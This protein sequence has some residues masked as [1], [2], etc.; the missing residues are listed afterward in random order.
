MRRGASALDVLLWLAIA[1][2][3]GLTAARITKFGALTIGRPRTVVS[4]GEAKLFEPL[5]VFLAEVA[6]RVPKDSTFSL[7]PP[8][9]R[10]LFNWS[11]Y[12]IAVG[13]MRG[14]RVIF[15]PRFIPA[16]AAGETPR[17]AACFGGEFN[18]PRFR[19]IRQL[20]GGSLY[21]AA[22]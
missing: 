14:R 4:N 3:L 17:F 8:S 2:L 1:A 9:G 13:Q 12:L 21:E 18:D 6:D 10:D 20:P 7:V 15:A 16:S 19:R 11:D 5:L 22:R